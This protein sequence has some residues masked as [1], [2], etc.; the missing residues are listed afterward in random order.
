MNTDIFRVESYLYKLIDIE[1]INESSQIDQRFDLGSGNLVQV[2]IN[3]RIKNPL[4]NKSIVK[5]DELGFCLNFWKNNLP[6]FRVDNKA[7]GFLHYHKDDLSQHQKIEGTYRLSE[8]ISFTFDLASAILKERFRE[9]IMISNSGFV[10][11]A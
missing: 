10:R 3:N 1:G 2:R 9:E 7:V 4:D 8:L 6:W 11:T 5:L